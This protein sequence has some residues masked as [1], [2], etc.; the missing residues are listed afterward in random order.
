MLLAEVGSIGDPSIELL[1][2]ENYMKRPL[3]L[4]SLNQNVKDENDESLPAE[5]SFAFRILLALLR[6]SLLDLG[7][8]LNTFLAV[9]DSG[10]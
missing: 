3:D 4:T 1:R 7:Q 9:A 2:V 8:I 6:L 5:A 10:S